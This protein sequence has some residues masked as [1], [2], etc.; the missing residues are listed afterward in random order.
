MEGGW[1]G[2]GSLLIFVS[3]FLWYPGLARQLALW[4]EVGLDWAACSF[5]SARFC[6][7]LAR[8]LAYGGGWAGWARLL[9]FCDLAVVVPWL[10]CKF[11]LWR[12]VGQDGAAYSVHTSYVANGPNGGKLTGASWHRPIGAAVCW[13]VTLC[14]AGQPAHLIG[15]SLLCAG[16]SYHRLAVTCSNI[17]NTG[18][19]ICDTM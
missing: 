2:L 12:E 17:P 8:P 10:S 14:P 16:T 6:G 3:T 5:L 18:G 13:K 9:T 15:A 4:R 1:A 7:N 11:A 19:K